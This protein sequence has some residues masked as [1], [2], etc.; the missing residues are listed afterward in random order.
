M[1]KQGQPAGQAPQDRGLASQI[2]PVTVD[3][4]RSIGY[5]GGITVAL[6]AGVIEPPLALFIA[7]IPF[8]KMPNR[9]TASKPVRFV[10]QVLD[11]SAKPMGACHVHIV[12]PATYL[13]PLPDQDV[14]WACTRA[15]KASMASAPSRAPSSSW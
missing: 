8:L 4:P 14:V 15:A 10:G 3:W 9:P 6:A 12:K 7:A 2:G 13:N 5:Y 1:A 11:G